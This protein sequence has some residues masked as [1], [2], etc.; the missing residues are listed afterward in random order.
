M[1]NDAKSF[2]G[3]HQCTVDNLYDYEHILSFNLNVL[4]SKVIITSVSVC[5]YATFNY[6]GTCNFKYVQF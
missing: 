4:I 5:V 6:I 1:I 2:V 3:C